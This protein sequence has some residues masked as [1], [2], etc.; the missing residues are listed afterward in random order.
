[1]NLPN[2]LTILRMLMVPL[3]LACF[4]LDRWLSWWNIL[5]A[6]VFFVADMTDV[7]DGRIARKY[8]L[9][10]DF[11]KL[12]DPMADK[13]LFLTA[14]IM[15]TGLGWLPPLFTVLFVAREIVV[16]AFRLVASTRGTVIAANWLGK[17][18]STLQ[19]IAIIA[20]LLENPLFRLINVRFDMICMW[21]AA[22]FT[23]WSMLDY[24]IKNWRV[25]KTK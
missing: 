19:V 21:L 6:A 24:I 12:M 14:F 13:L 15:L 16:S 10:T 3:F 9:V 7:V 23:L 5:A 18:K 17:T 20:M 4:F 22:I 11:G 1:M 25:V 8:N 2:K